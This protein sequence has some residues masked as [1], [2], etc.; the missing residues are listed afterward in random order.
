[1][2]VYRVLIKKSAGRVEGLHHGGRVP[3]AQAIQRGILSYVDIK[4]NIF[5]RSQSIVQGSILFLV[6]V[7]D[8]GN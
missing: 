5:R 4:L 6:D 7:K 2:I 3:Q 8:P 1:M